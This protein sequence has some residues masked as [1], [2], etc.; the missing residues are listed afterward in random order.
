MRKKMKKFFFYILKV[1]EK[2]SRIRSWIRIQIHTSE[3]GIQIRTKM[4][5]MPNTA[6]LFWMLHG[7]HKH[8][9]INLHINFFLILFKAH[10]YGTLYN[11]YR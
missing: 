9:P 7:L 2:R 1:T 3:V 10:R 8:F 4:S 6:I 5:Q 11:N